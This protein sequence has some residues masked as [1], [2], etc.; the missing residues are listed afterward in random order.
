MM[1]VQV[2]VSGLVLALGMI[3][4]LAATYTPPP[5]ATQLST[6]TSQLTNHPV[7]LGPAEKVGRELRFEQ[8]LSVTGESTHSLWKLASGAQLNAAFVAASEQLPGAVLYSCS[9]RDCGRSTAWANLV[10]KDALLYGQDRYQR[11]RVVQTGPSQLQLLY[12]VQRGNRRIHLYAETIDTSAASDSVDDALD[13]NSAEQLAVVRNALSSTG[14]VRLKLV[15]GATGA[16]DVGALAILTNTGAALAGVKVAELY[17]VC[18]L[19]GADPASTLLAASN[20]CAT[21]ATDALQKGHIEALGDAP[22]AD[23]RNRAR[24]PAIT[25]VPFGA[26]PLLP[27]L[28]A[29]SSSPAEVED[30]S[31]ANRIELIAPAHLWR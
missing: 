24:P 10:F 22:S 25:F 29:G 9:G 7:L 6:A 3:P 14:A 21:V 8:S 26:G 30:P 23:S 31:G 28:P 13:A 18:H 16:L 4:A 27:R 12:A 11:Y 15:P 1:N 17:V 19:Y 2:V 20:N 5:N